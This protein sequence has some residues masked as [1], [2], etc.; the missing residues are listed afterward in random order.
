M[1]ES[2]ILPS[3]CCR[4]RCC[5]VEEQIHRGNI[6]CCIDFWVC[7]IKSSGTR[8]TKQRANTSMELHNALFIRA[9]GCSTRL[10]TDVAQLLEVLPC[11]YHNRCD[12]SSYCDILCGICLK[13]LHHQ[14]ENIRSN[15]VDAQGCGAGCV[16][17]SIPFRSE[18][19]GTHSLLRGWINHTHNCNLFNL[20]LGSHFQYTPELIG[21]KITY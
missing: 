20:D 19:Q 7:D 13:R 14:R 10:E 2:H 18:V 12:C 4:G 8:Q 6:H 9:S 5:C 3:L 21:V 17:C 15:N 11:H 1:G 16:G